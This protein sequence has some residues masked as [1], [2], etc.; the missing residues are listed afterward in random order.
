MT[1]R[2]MIYLLQ[3][4]YRDAHNAQKRYKEKL[5]AGKITADEYRREI[6]YRGGQMDLIDELMRNIMESYED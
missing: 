4:Y 5:E 1:N 2:Q 3:T 6:D